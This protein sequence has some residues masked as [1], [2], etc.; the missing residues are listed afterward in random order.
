VTYLRAQGEL[1]ALY[2]ETTDLVRRLG[3][4]QV[5]NL[6]TI[7]GNIANG[8]PIGDMPPVLI[9]AGAQIRLRSGPAK[10]DLDL[11]NYFIAY[12][13]QDRRPAEF[14]ESIFIPR[15]KA[16]AVLKVYKVSKRFDQDISSV[17]G[18]FHLTFGPGR[19]IVRSARICFGGMAAIPSRALACERFLAGKPWTDDVIA[20]ATEILRQEFQPI[21]DWRASAQYRVKIAGN[22]LRR[23]FLETSTEQRLQLSG[24]KET[25]HAG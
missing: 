8:S 18:A 13:Q 6:G 17:C 16:R 9:A 2:P 22:L 15:P 12:G 25:I 5:R 20:E 11:E 24:R 21:S 3:S 19:H 4:V 23:A 1:A 14:L 7:G 10:R